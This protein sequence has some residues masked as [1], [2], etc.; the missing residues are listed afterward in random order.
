MLRRAVVILRQV[1]ALRRRRAAVRLRLVA[2]TPRRT[3][4]EMV[5]RSLTAAGLLAAVVLALAGQARAADEVRPAD[6]IKELPQEKPKQLEGVELTEK[7]GDDAFLDAKFLDE[8]GKPVVLSD[9]FDTGLPVVL[10]LNYSDCPMLCGV[11]LGALVKTLVEIPHADGVATVV[12]GRQFHMVTI[13]LN[14]NE[15]PARASKTKEGYVARFDDKYRSSVRKGWHFLTGD[16]SQIRAVADSVGFGYRYLESQDDY[17]HPTAI[18]VLDKDGMIIRYL[19]GI[20]YG[21]TTF[22]ESIFA[23]GTSS[24][25]ASVGFIYSCFHYDSDA[26]SYSGFG[27]RLMTY[28]GSAFALLL[29]AGLTWHLT[30]T[31]KSRAGV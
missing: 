7:T 23:A 20:E 31:R 6:R 13:S 11:Q 4:R 17:L 9:Y 3:R 19:K 8:D 30:R 14:P 28:V 21:P 25:Q 24:P 22:V 18:M 5:T 1:A 12:P 10:T 29:L 26:N 15:T 16:E 27:R 2:A